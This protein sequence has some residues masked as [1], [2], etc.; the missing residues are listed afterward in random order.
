MRMKSPL[1][2][3][4]KMK[5]E[6]I[7]RILAFV[8]LTLLLVIGGDV[9]CN[10]E[11]EK[12]VEEEGISA[13]K[14]GVITFDGTVKV[15]VGKY[16]YIPKVQGF[17]IVVQGP[18][19]VG[20][21]KELI[22]QVVRGEG[23]FNPENPSILVAN[24][25]ELKEAEDVWRNIYTRTEEPVLDDYLDLMTRD[26]FE[27]LKD[28]SYDKKDSW[29]EKERVKVYGRLEEETVKEGEKKKA[30]YKFVVLDGKGKEIGTVLIDSFTDFA[31]YYMNKLRLF[32]KFWFY[33]TIK[34]TVDWSIRRS[35]REL[36]H[37]DV[38][39]AGLF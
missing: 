21:T 33:I 23:K 27:V 9:A 38:L 25:I 14:E 4:G 15:A 16:V 13:T 30:N 20:D 12:T 34:D 22:G 39:F 35:T 24:T 6:K 31:L 32:D 3:E 5:R 28:I 36:F 26:E 7:V 1:S 11:A 10:R 19:E 29:E 2:Q 18:I 37:A 17:D 8:T